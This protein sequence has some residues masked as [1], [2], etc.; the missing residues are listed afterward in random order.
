MRLG[1]LLLFL[2]SLHGSIWDSVVYSKRESC[3]AYY[4][5]RHVLEMDSFGSL[6]NYKSVEFLLHLI[7]QDYKASCMQPKEAC[8]QFMESATQCMGFLKSHTTSEIIEVVVP[9]LGHLMVNYDTL[10]PFERGRLMGYVIG[11]YGIDILAFNGTVKGIKTFRQLKAANRMA[12]LDALAF[13]TADSIEVLTTR[14]AAYLERNQKIRQPGVLKIHEG[15]QGKHIVGHPNYNSREFKSIFTHPD[16]QALIDVHAGSGYRV[17]GE[18][19][20][21]GYLEVV[22]FG[23]EIGLV[24]QRE[25]QENIATT[26]AKSLYAKEGVHIV[27]RVPL[28]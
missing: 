24:I 26:W 2:T 5:P 23:E 17:L 8:S 20:T 10:S 28:E 13:G 12:T 6:E 19:G 1:F 25:T 14:S 9:E 4:C 21:P 22:N 3:T 15:R 16:P 18:F 7:P 11:K 27:P